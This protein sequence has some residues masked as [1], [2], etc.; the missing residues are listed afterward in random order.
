MSLVH[1]WTELRARTTGMGNAAH[2]VD[3]AAVEHD[4]P[5]VSLRLKG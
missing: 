4:A 2:V 5:T 1:H 3:G